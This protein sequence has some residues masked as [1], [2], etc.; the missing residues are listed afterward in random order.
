MI[1]IIVLI[2]I[3]FGLG[4]FVL[5][6]GI[7]FL[8]DTLKNIGEKHIKPVLLKYTKN[9]VTSFLSGAFLS[10]ILQGSTPVMLCTIGL[11]NAGMM[12]F[13]SSL[14]IMYGANL[15]TTLS[16][17]IISYNVEYM[18]YVILVIGLLL[19]VLSGNK[20]IIA[21]G[22]ILVSIGL[23][24]TGIS[25]LKLSMPI[26]G[27]LIMQ[28]ELLSKHG[29]SIFVNFL[30][31]T[32]ITAIT[33]S[34]AA[35]T[36]IT[37]LFY[38]QGILG[39]LA[40]TAII[41]GSNLGTCFTAQFASYNSGKEAIKMAWSHSIYNLVGCIFGL[42]FINQFTL[43]I[44]GMIVLFNWNT[45][46]FPALCHVMINLI[47]ALVFI[48]VTPLFYKMINLMFDSRSINAFNV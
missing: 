47:S 42:I 25:I 17:V 10:V 31:S 7:K 33:H 22:N 1:K 3:Y 24:F 5:N 43:M 11:I 44:D 26:I 30:F 27:N 46:L 36:A 16:A 34:S 45:D 21:T 29:N 14:G 23:I 28:S 18:K 9:T 38:K 20:K 6:Y 12:P 32:V 48:P 13:Y 4:I 39:K 41:L 2:A 40:V 15:G 35:V 8:S 37:I 19:K